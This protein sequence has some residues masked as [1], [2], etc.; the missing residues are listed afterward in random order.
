MAEWHSDGMRGCESLIFT[1]SR[2]TNTYHISSYFH[3]NKIF[4]LIEFC[5]R[6]LSIE[7]TEGHTH[8]HIDNSN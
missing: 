6:F 8:V 4:K 5:F 3:S 7:K 2:N 1:L